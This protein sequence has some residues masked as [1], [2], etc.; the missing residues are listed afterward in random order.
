[1]VSRQE[2]SQRQTDKKAQR[3]VRLAPKIAPDNSCTATVESFG[4]FGGQ[5]TLHPIACTP[6]PMQYTMAAEEDEP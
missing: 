3:Q 5:R 6:Y 1:M 2:Q 4:R